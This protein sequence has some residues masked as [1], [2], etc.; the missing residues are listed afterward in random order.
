MSRSKL[1]IYVMLITFWPVF[2]CSGQTFRIP[3]SDT[4]GDGIADV[5]DIDDDN[6]GI[7]DILESNGH[8]P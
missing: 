6:D 5:Y 8:R 7:P 2:F 4:D 1:L 3:Y